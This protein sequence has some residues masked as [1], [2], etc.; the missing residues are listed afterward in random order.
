MS[1]APF[2]V[3]TYHSRSRDVL[4][5]ILKVALHVGATEV[6]TELGNLSDNVEERSTLAKLVVLVDGDAVVEQGVDK[7]LLLT[8]LRAGKV[9]VDKPDCLK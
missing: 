1:K 5:L 9:G 2:T 6:L 4:T 3:S 8:G 7:T